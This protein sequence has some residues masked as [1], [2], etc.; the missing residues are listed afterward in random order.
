M[1]HLKG[2]NESLTADEVE[3]LKEFCEINL[4]YLLDEDFIV[5]IDSRFGTT[6]N[7]SFNLKRELGFTWNEISDHFIPFLQRLSNKY[8][9]IDRIM[10]SFQGTGIR[11]NVACANT[12]TRV[13]SLINN[14]IGTILPSETLI[15]RIFIRIVDKI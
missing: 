7:V 3:E 15:R 13:E 2:F 8:V 10:I 12:E 9:I 4:A 5:D 1:K 11:Y 6:G 14:D